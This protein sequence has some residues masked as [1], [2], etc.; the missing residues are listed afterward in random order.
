M[1]S[2]RAVYA[3][4]GQ[5]RHPPAGE[6][7]LGRLLDLGGVGVGRR[8]PA[9][10]GDLHVGHLGLGIH[11][12]LDLYGPRTAGLKQLEGLVYT[13]GNLVGLS[14]VAVPLGD[15]GEHAQLVLGIV[16]GPDSFV[17]K[18]FLRGA[19]HGQDGGGREVGLAYAAHGVGGR[20][21]PCW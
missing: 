7:Q 14:H 3:A 13:V 19:G 1:C 16:G 11:G 2:P 8:H 17:V 4:S 9:E 5:Y 10:L 12:D 6:K 20:R 21:V 15:G 18:G